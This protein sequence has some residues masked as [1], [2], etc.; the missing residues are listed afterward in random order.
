M[1]IA[2]NVLLSATLRSRMIS[3]LPVP[4]NSSKITSS[5]RLPVSISAV[6]MIVSDPPSSIFRAAPKNRFRR[7]TR[8]ASIPPTR[9]PLARGRNHGVVRPSQPRDAVQQDHHVPLVLHQP[10]GLLQHH[11]RH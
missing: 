3:E 5:I 10:L 7:R 6:A 1:S 4:L 2:G 8:L 9:Q 11:L